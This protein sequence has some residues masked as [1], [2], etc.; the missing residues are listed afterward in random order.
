MWYGKEFVHQ[1]VEEFLDDCR[2]D[3][4]RLEMDLCGTAAV[5]VV[6]RERSAMRWDIVVTAA[7]GSGDVGAGPTVKVVPHPLQEWR[8]RQFGGFPL[9]DYDSRMGSG[10]NE[11][12]RADRQA[13]YGEKPK[14]KAMV[15]EVRTLLQNCFE[16]R[17]GVL[18]DLQSHTL[19]T[20]AIKSYNNNNNL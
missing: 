2:A 19:A 18:R 5:G 8:E 6:T 17:P 4:L 20:C 1:P 3:K 14:E 12:G 15:R 10:V 11:R 7:A 13:V 16:E 9:G